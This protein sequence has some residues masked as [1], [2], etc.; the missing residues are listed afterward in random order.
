MVIW[1]FW[2]SWKGNLTVNIRNAGQHKLLFFQGLKWY[3]LYIV[4]TGYIFL[5]YK[6]STVDA[7]IGVFDRKEK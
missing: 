4:K 3:G 7:N 6:G 5:H 1:L 2:S